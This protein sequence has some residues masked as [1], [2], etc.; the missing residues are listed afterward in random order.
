M[1]RPRAVINYFASLSV[2]TSNLY[3]NLYPEPPEFS[4]AQ[5]LVFNFNKYIEKKNYA[6]H[7]IIKP[8]AHRPDKFF[9]IAVNNLIPWID[10]YS[11]RIN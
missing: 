11:E 2:P 8:P 6:R 5:S 3:G 1:M 4:A 7:K 9:Q 10:Y